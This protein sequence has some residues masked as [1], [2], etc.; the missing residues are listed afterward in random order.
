MKKRDWRDV[1]Y[2]P[3][4]GG[5]NNPTKYFPHGYKE[6]IEASEIYASLL[7]RQSPLAT[8]YRAKVERVSSLFKDVIA[9][10]DRSNWHKAEVLNDE[11]L[12]LYDHRMKLRQE[13][14]DINGKRLSLSILSGSSTFQETLAIIKCR[15]AFE[16]MTDEQTFQLFCE[17]FEH[18]LH[19]YDEHKEHWLREAFETSE[20]NPILDNMLSKER[21]RRGEVVLSSTPE[22]DRQ[23]LEESENRIQ[24]WQDEEDHQ[25]REEQI[26]GEARTRNK[27]FAGLNFTKTHYKGSQRSDHVVE[28]GG[29][30]TEPVPPWSFYSAITYEYG[31]CFHIQVP[32]SII[33]IQD[34]ED[35]NHLILPPN[36]FNI[37]LPFQIIPAIYEQSGTLVFGQVGGGIAT[38]LSGAEFIHKHEKFGN[39][40]LYFAALLKEGQYIAIRRQGWEN[41]S[42]REGKI[43]EVM[44]FSSNN[45]VTI[46]MKQYRE[47]PDLYE[48]KKKI[49]GGD[50]HLA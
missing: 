16:H 28:Y 30:L 45:Y 50:I 35:N 14:A 48:L 46:P 17:E 38:V 40:A 12:A 33:P 10:F 19:P 13:N 29:Y 37:V 34:P 7:T 43:D 8:E 1:L 6:Y 22:P 18:F 21:Q 39:N 47:Y 23:I 42:L 20:V 3:K 5:R 44:I 25:R 15:A 26:K 4:I 2:Y 41:I 9:R 11:F 24:S 36:S 31:K 49:E 32:G 27:N